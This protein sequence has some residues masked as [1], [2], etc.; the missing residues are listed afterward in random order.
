MSETAP[1]PETV[2]IYTDG[3][4]SGNPGPGGWGAI[5]RFKGIEKELKGGESPTT[6]NRME[7]MAVLVALNTLTRSCAVDVYTDSEYVKKGMT[8]WLRGWKARGWKTADKKPVKNDDL[9]KALDEAAA[10]H[11]VSWHWVKG[12]AG[13]PENER[14]D[15]LAREG[16]ADLRART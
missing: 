11:K 9:W 5:L 15:A 13:H 8:E 16:I 1:K 10:R 4:C 7:M 3:A 2:E 6:N 14:A 12:H